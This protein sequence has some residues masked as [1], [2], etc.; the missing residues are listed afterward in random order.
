MTRPRSPVSV[1]VI[2]R[3]APARR[4]R[5]AIELGLSLAAGSVLPLAFAPWELWPLAPVSLLALYALLQHAAPRRAALTGFV[6]GLGHFGFGVNWVY[7]SLTLFGGATAGFAGLLTALLIVV[8]ASFPAGAAW[9]WA[10]LRDSR[11]A[12]ALTSGMRYRHRASDA[13]LFA[14]AW[15]LCELARGK[16]LGG[17]P[18]IIIGYSQTD[19]PMGVLAPAIGVYGIGF[20]LTGAT[21]SLLPLA[22]TAS[23]RSRAAAGISIVLVTSAVL[24]A[25][26]LSFSE[27]AERT[28][29]GVRLVQANIAQA[30]KFRPELLDRSLNEYVRLSRE[31]LP[32]D[33]DLVVWPETAIPISFARVEQAL[34]PAV[35]GFEAQGIDVLTGGFERSDEATWNAVRQLTGERQTY[36]KRHLVPF[37]EYL[38]FRDLLELFSAFIRIPG[39]DL[40][41]G[42]GAHEPLKVA[43]ESIGVSICYEDVFGEKMQALVPEAGVLV[44]VSND[45]WFGDSAAPHQHE[46]KARMRARELARPMIRVTNTGVSSSIAFDG[47]VEGRIAQD[48]KGVLDVRVVPRT[49]TTWFARTGNWPVFIVTTCI[50]VAITRRRLAASRRRLGRTGDRGVDECPSTENADRCT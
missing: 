30:M 26:A 27:P 24:T 35:A 31:R 5:R 29:L 40:S 37:G 21:A 48:V 10:R 14:A 8:L 11:P 43:G 46:Q 36:R 6:F 23:R 34:A 19:G 25:P 28:S 47:T 49:G 16:V 18:W 3:A 42:T 1:G 39:S 22:L 32:D 50:V 4:T 45:A 41:P 12:S 7:H 2:P 17:F 33:I 20:L 9:L 13:W 44:N 38:P 15:S